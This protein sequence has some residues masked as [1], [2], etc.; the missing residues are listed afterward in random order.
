MDI[1]T[2]GWNEHWDGL[3]APHRELGR[4]PARVSGLDRDRCTVLG[5]GGAEWPAE[6]S[7]R[8]RH[9]A[10]GPADFPAVGDWVALEG[11]SHEGPR[12]IASVLPRARSLAR[13]VPGEVTQAQIIAANVD[14]AFI[15]CG[16]D[17]D[18]NVRR[19]ERYLA[20]A[21]DGG[22]TPVV[23][24]N[25]SD[26]A[27]EVEARVAEAEA[28]SPGVPVIA[29]SA[30]EGRGLEALAPWLAPGRTVALLGS[31]GAGKS[32]LA[33]ALLGA[34]RQ[35]TSAVREDDS[36]GRHTTTRRELL[37]LP[38]GAWLVDTPGLRELQLWADESA[39]DE[40]FPEIAELAARCR[41]RDCRHEREP[42]CAVL[43]A[44][45]EGTL[46]GDRLES[47]RK[48]Q[49]ELRWLAR[50]QDQ[51]LR[52]AEEARWRE[53]GRSMRTRKK[54]DPRFRGPG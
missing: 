23:A 53:I 25:K 8:L 4:E 42:G 27:G 36:R 1:E 39:L 47:W 48:L 5:A 50:R 43:A 15:V 44:A 7:G 13:K 54:L 19:I 31:S 49:R 2:L 24:L 29:L 3:F 22:V 11:A 14:T 30:L 16:L 52:A 51:S 18:F 35:R 21:W 45:A 17:H 6:V 34:A 46:P 32:T 12:R 10:R 28:V 38:G 26:L 37:A 9:E 33:N 41:F 20:T 40:S